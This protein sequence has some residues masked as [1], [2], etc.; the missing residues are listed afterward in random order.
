MA[1]YIEFPVDYSHFNVSSADYTVS[2]GDIEVCWDNQTEMFHAESEV[3][4]TDYLKTT[5]T[6]WPDQADL[7]LTPSVTN[8][9]LYSSPN[10]FTTKF[11]Q[12]GSN[13]NQWCIKNSGFGKFFEVF[14]G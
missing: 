3:Y 4:V 7:P 1:L 12:N 14:K 6:A 11:Y 2:G 9:T 8:E 5:V 10:G 13:V